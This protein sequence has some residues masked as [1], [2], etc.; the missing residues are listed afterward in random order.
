MS[1]FRSQSLLRCHRFDSVDTVWW[2]KMLASCLSGISLHSSRWVLVCFSKRHGSNTS[3][4]TSNS[5]P[6]LTFQI[7]SRNPFPQRLFQATWGRSLF[8]LAQRFYAIP[9]APK[10]PSYMTFARCQS[11][12]CSLEAI[13]AAFTHFDEEKTV[14]SLIYRYAVGNPFLFLNLGCLLRVLLYRSIQVLGTTCV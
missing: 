14:D 13:P 9:Q 4:W 1:W 6:S 11:Y 7:I 8:Q 12:H 2:P 10:M 3:D 5:N